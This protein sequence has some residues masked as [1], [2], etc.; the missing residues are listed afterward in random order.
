MKEDLLKNIATAISVKC[1]KI[2]ADYRKQERQACLLN[3]EQ[4]INNILYALQKDLFEVM[5]EHAYPKLANIA[6]PSYI[7][8]HGWRTVPAGAVVYQY[9]LDKELY[10]D[11]PKRI[12][13]PVL[14]RIQRSINLDIA[15][16]QNVLKNIYPLTF[17]QA[18][19]CFLFYGMQVTCMK[20]MGTFVLMEIAT[21]VQP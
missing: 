11:M 4:C 17:I 15:Q 13:E 9:E 12:P 7:R 5:G 16:K 3:R 10:A 1:K 18:N 2:Y 20:D 6:H 21:N 8:I 19:F 14:S